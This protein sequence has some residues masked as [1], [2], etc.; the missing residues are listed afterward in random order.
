MD[1]QKHRLAKFGL[2]VPSEIDGEEERQQGKRNCIAWSVGAYMDKPPNGILAHK[3]K[4][5][6]KQGRFNF[7]C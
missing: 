4:I 1:A 2:S 6:D 3:K 7:S 5:V